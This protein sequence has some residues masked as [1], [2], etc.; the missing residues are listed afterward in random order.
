MAGSFYQ[1]SP[2]T[3]DSNA[4]ELVL[5]LC[6]LATDGATWISG[7]YVIDLK[8]GETELRVELPANT[9]VTALFTPDKGG[10]TLP[11]PARQLILSWMRKNLPW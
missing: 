11:P 7:I 3:W 8:T 5:G 4:N 1:T 10:V 6:G 2:L 9:Y